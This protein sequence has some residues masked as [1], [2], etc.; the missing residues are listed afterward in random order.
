MKRE[1]DGTI[2]DM[3]AVVPASDELKRL[4]AETS[5]AAKIKTKKKRR[6]K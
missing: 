3:R 6:S 1:V 4:G 2:I 5:G